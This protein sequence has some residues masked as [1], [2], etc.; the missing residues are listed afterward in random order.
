MKNYFIIG[1]IKLR[2]LRKIVAFPPLDFFKKTL[3]ASWMYK[4]TNGISIFKI[5]MSLDYISVWP[6]Y[7]FC[8]KPSDLSTA[9]GSVL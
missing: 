4:C 9:R 3:C 6:L 8:L 1:L 5:F 7:L 2:D